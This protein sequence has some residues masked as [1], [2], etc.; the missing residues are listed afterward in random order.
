LENSTAPVENPDYYTLKVLRALAP[1]VLNT[2]LKT[3]LAQKL[4]LTGR[5]VESLLT[6][7]AVEVKFPVSDGKEAFLNTLLVIP[8]GD[9][10]LGGEHLRIEHQEAFETLKNLTQ[11]GFYAVFEKYPF[12]DNSFTLALYAALKLGK[13]AE[14]FAY[15]GAVTPEG[16]IEEVQF[17]ESKKAAAERGGVPLLF[18]KKGVLE[19]LE[20]FERFFGGIELP[21]S[22]LFDES[23]AQTF[24]RIFPFGA[25]YLQ[26]VFHL[27]TPLHR[28]ERLDD[29]AESFKEFYNWIKTLLDEISEKIPSGFEYSI[30]TTQM[31]GAASFLVGIELS[32]AHQRV[33]FYN[34]DNQ[35]RNYKKL[36]TIGNDLIPPTPEVDRWFEVFKPER[37][38]RVLIKTK[39]GFEERRNTLQLV[40]KS[41]K[42][43]DEEAKE[44]G[45]ALGKFLR[46]NLSRGRSYTLE[47]ELPN[48][49]ALALGYYAEDHLW[50]KVKHKGKI[51]FS[52]RGEGKVY[53][54]SWE[55]LAKVNLDGWLFSFREVEEDEIPQEVEEF[56]GT[57]REGD[58]LVVSLGGKVYLVE[59]SRG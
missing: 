27:K 3:K 42:L 34:W 56:K 18:S 39:S 29:T 59:V 44:I 51:V 55:E 22:A 40:S 33:N 12:R 7:E 50:L 23:K 14:N 45:A 49:V 21:L 28:T 6:A 10:P 11:K 17:L 2:P 57:L 37:F 52:T 35:L 25:E 30:A 15:T 43:P 16:K 48:A 19:T 20:D 9:K 5:E 38:T 31:V 58:T 13:R 53:K 4:N 36:Y 24:N 1:R 41:E 26:Q 8:F 32:K 46:Q 54:T 47:M